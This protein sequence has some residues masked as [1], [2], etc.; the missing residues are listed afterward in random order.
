MHVKTCRWGFD[1][2]DRILV[3]GYNIH[4]LLKNTFVLQ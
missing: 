2:Y 4:F 1:K 3:R